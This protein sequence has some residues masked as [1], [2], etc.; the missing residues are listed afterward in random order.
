MLCFKGVSPPLFFRWIFTQNNK[1]KTHCQEAYRQRMFNM[2]AITITPR[3]IKNSTTYSDMYRLT[4]FLHEH[5]SLKCVYFLFSSLRDGSGE[6]FS[7]NHSALSCASAVCCPISGRLEEHQEKK[8]NQIR[9]RCRSLQLSGPKLLKEPQSCFS[10]AV[11]SPPPP[12]SAITHTP[13]PRLHVKE[14]RRVIFNYLRVCCVAVIGV[15][16]HGPNGRQK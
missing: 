6:R 7:V 15:G 8:K 10:P 12:H 16:E 14:N 5:I 3:P 4:I 1:G 11:H 13:P 2:D 9:E